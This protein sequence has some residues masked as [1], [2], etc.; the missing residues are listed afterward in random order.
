MEASDEP[1]QNFFALINNIPFFREF[2][3]EQKKEIAALKNKVDIYEPNRTIVSEGGKDVAVFVLLKGEAIV[4]RNDLPRVIINTLT[5]GALFGEVSFL[6]KTPRTT[7]IIA[8][9]EAK[10]LRLD[11]DMFEKL[12]SDT[13]DRLKDKFIDVLVSRMNEMNSA[14]MKLKVELE[15]IS[16]AATDYQQEFDRILKSGKTMKEVMGGINS[17]ITSLIR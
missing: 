10:V 15:A 12:K 13:R 11:G 4:T 6:T 7:N 17:T 14:L 16:Q 5:M 8:K 2:S 3:K 9:S 1:T